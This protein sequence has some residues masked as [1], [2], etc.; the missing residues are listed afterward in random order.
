MSETQ[1][2]ILI[3]LGNIVGNILYDIIGYL[4]SNQGGD[5]E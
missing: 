1:L 5:D 2:F 4:I 3:I